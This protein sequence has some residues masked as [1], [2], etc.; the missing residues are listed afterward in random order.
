MNKMIWVISTVISSFVKQQA[1]YMYRTYQYCMSFYLLYRTRW[2]GAYIRKSL[3]SRILITTHQC[4]ILYF[5]WLKIL[6]KSVF[7]Q[8]FGTKNSFMIF[9]GKA[10]K[11]RSLKHWSERPFQRLEI[12]D[13]AS[14]VWSSKNLSHGSIQNTYEI[15]KCMQRTV[16]WLL[17]G[18][19]LLSI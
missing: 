19:M 6:T 12:L 9:A 14:P 4:D 13:K 2:N 16:T 15:R 18:L 7:N 8:Y 11:T 17:T 3:Q 5:M 10:S 1:V